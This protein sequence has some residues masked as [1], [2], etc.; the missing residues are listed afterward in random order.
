[1]GR[2]SSA[3]VLVSKTPRYTLDLLRGRGEALLHRKEN[4]GETTRSMA[5]PTAFVSSICGSKGEAGGAGEEE[6]ERGGRSR[7][8]REKSMGRV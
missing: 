3:G 4:T 1:M 5:R 7:V 6:E 2:T 8:A